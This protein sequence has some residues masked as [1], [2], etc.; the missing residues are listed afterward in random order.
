MVKAYEVPAVTE[1]PVNVVLVPLPG[2][3]GDV[4]DGAGLNAA[5]VNPVPVGVKPVSATEPELVTVSVPVP[6]PEP[7]GTTR[8][9][10]I[11]IWAVT[12]AL[13]AVVLK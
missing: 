2:G 1:V 5:K 8:V 13:V 12:C 4:L 7:L 6:A 9:A 11:W 3:M 10:L